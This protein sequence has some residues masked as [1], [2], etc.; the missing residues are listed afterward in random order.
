MIRTTIKIP[1]HRLKRDSFER[2]EKS[3]LQLHIESE[4]SRRKER[5]APYEDITEVSIILIKMYA[6]YKHLLIA[7][8]I[9]ITS[10]IIL[11]V[12]IS[13]HINHFQN[14]YQRNFINHYYYHQLTIVATPFH[15]LDLDSVDVLDVVAEYLLIEL[16]FINDLQ[17]T[18]M[19]IKKWIQKTLTN[20]IWILKV[21]IL[22][23]NLMLWI[24]GKINK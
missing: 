24:I 12:Y 15:I 22:T 4:L 11:L 14:H 19:I 23:M 10:I 13:S 1:L 18:I 20:L 16:D 21:M 7:I 17:H 8:I 9:I 6:V 3:P 2:P 5:D